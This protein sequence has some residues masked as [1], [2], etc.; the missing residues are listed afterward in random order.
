MALPLGADEGEPNRRVGPATKLLPTVG[1]RDAKREMNDMGD[2][3]AAVRLR[4]IKNPAELNSSDTDCRQKEP[5]C[6]AK[7]CPQVATAFTSYPYL[8]VDSF[9][10]CTPVWSRIRSEHLT[11]FPRLCSRMSC[12]WSVAR[13][14]HTSPL[15][16]NS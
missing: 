5:A 2:V 16:T 7:P 8:R 6:P 15:V 14:F 11:N 13:A 12:K 3:M 10:S 4:V 9:R 1:N